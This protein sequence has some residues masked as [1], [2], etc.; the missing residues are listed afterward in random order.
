MV[1]YALYHQSG[2]CQAVWVYVSCSQKRGAAPAHSSLS[3]YVQICGR[4]TC[5]TYPLNMCTICSCSSCVEGNIRI[6]QQILRSE[7]DTKWASPRIHILS[8]AELAWIFTFLTCELHWID[9]ISA[10]QQTLLERKSKEI[11]HWLSHCEFD[12][13]FQEILLWAL[14]FTWWRLSQSL[15]L[16]SSSHDSR[17]FWSSVIT[18]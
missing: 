17:C 10:V 14:H 11:S 5:D 18:N 4:D 13:H 1:H 7:R 15:M 9:R 2:V 16:C 6:I 12:L 3:K 8:L